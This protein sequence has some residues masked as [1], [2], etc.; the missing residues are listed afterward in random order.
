MNVNMDIHTAERIL[1]STGHRLYRVDEKNAYDTAW[2]VGPVSDFDEESNN[3]VHSYWADNN[4]RPKVVR[5]TMWYRVA[6]YLIEHPEGKTKGDI[7]RALG[8]NPSGLHDLW[9]PLQRMV[10]AGILNWDEERKYTLTELGEDR[11]ETATSNSESD[12]SAAEDKFEK[13]YGKSYN[14]EA[15]RNNVLGR[16]RE[17][18]CYLIRNWERENGIDLPRPEEREI[19]HEIADRVTDPATGQLLSGWE[20]KAKVI[21]DREFEDLYRSMRKKNVSGYF[22]K[23]RS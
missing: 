16:S 18:V 9:S 3:F 13:K 5:R 19:E 21:L 6:E 1:E 4:V 23:R 20:K 17:Q 22:D 8:I 15:M 14:D 2:E 7:Q 11:Y 12:K 10:K